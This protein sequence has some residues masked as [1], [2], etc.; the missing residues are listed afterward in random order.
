MSKRSR[1]ACERCK[2]SK[3]KC[4]G[5]P[6][7][8][9]CTV[10]QKAGVECSILFQKDES[11]RYIASLEAK[12]RHLEAT[13]ASASPKPAKNEPRKYVSLMGPNLAFLL[14]RSL[15]GSPLNAHSNKF[16][17]ETTEPL[18]PAEGAY[19]FGYLIENGTLGSEMIDSCLRLLYPRFPI[20]HFKHAHQLHEDRVRVLGP[21]QT[22]E[23]L[24]NKFI[25]LM[26]YAVGLRVR[27]IV[28]TGVSDESLAHNPDEVYAAAIEDLETITQVVDIDSVRCL[29]LVAFYM[30]R[31]AYG[32]QIWHLCG[33]IMRYCIDLNMHRREAG[34]IT[35][36]QLP[37][38]M[39][40]RRVFWSAYVLERSVCMHFNRP[41]C[42]SDYDIN[43]ELPYNI[44][45]S[46]ME[47]EELNEIINVHPERMG[48]NV[49]TDMSIGIC[50]M[51]LRR[52]DSFIQHSIYRVDKE[53]DMP[54][55]LNDITLMYN[56]V[57]KWKED[58]PPFKEEHNRIFMTLLYHKTMRIMLVPLIS[59][60][61]DVSSSPQAQFYI[62]QCVKSCGSICLIAKQMIQYEWYCHSFIALHSLYVSA[63]TL[64]YCVLT[65]KL[66]WSIEVSTCLQSCSTALFVIGER[67]PFTKTYLRDAYEQVLN[68]TMEQ[69]A[70]KESASK[71]RHFR[72]GGVNVLDK[73]DK[74]PEIEIYPTQKY[75]DM[76]LEEA[77]EVPISDDFEDLW[78]IISDQK[79]LNF[80]DKSISQFNF[81]LDY[82]FQY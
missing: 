82:N 75:V 70:K 76:P 19:D 34:P 77:L 37:D 1:L 57:Q 5:V 78:Q 16:F 3:R 73:P 60:E 46:V 49:I 74:S 40:R 47:A 50:M 13:A 18:P 35:I 15:D 30:L 11:A 68:R 69:M 27:Q 2:R 32:Q 66:E 8:K 80:D 45:D 28:K 51:K 39:M 17:P 59:K 14:H 67:M 9:Q 81:G 42:L 79:P 38:S 20:I 53:L 29:I 72:I 36:D 41:L 6:D 4:D 58:L 62:D 56:R 33:L 23:D 7:L 43:A 48:P 25:L 31:S 24:V 55:L 63:M 12:I 61:V 54:T 44:D 21:P 22:R 26:L 52:I 65:E 71:T 64:I 10:C